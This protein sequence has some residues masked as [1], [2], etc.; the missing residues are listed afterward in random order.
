MLAAMIESDGFSEQSIAGLP[1]AVEVDLTRDNRPNAAITGFIFEVSA[2][3]DT[4]D[5]N[6][7]PGLDDF[8]AAV[9]WAIPFVSSREERLEQIDVGA[10]MRVHVGPLD[11]PFT[12]QML[13]GVLAVQL[14]HMIVEIVAA[15]DR[16]G[17]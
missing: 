17:A 16:E 15:Q 8:V 13:R 1:Q 7:L 2:P 9:A 4:A 6:A 10:S 12:A 3:V 11:E 5:E 14:G